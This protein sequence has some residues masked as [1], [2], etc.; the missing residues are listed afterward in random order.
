MTVCH[1]SGKNTSRKIK[2]DISEYVTSPNS[3]NELL[4][5]PNR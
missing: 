3:A 4:Y 2:E 5:S 1:F